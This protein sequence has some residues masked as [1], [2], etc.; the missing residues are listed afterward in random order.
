MTN[1]MFKVLNSTAAAPV[2]LIKAK[3]APPRLPGGLVRRL[4]LHELLDKG[5]EYPLT[6]VKAPAGYGKTTAVLD[7]LRVSGHACCWISL[8]ENDNHPARFFSY[9]ACALEEVLPGLEVRIA[10][11]LQAGPGVGMESALSIIIEELS[12]CSREFILVLDNGHW[13]QDPAI[14]RG[15]SFILEYM[16]LSMHVIIITRQE[17]RLSLSR[18]R[19]KNQVAELGIADL[20]F[21]KT[22]IAAFFRQRDLELPETA[23]VRLEELSEGWAAGLQMAAL[24]MDGPSGAGSHEPDSWLEGF[25]GRNNYVRGYFDEEVFFHWPEEIR[26]F[27]LQTSILKRLN[28]PLCQAVTGTEGSQEILAMLAGANAFILP[29][30]QKQNWYRHHP[31]WAQYLAMRLE[32]SAAGDVRDLHLK[33]GGWCQDKALWEEAIHHFLVAGEHGQALALMEKAA[34]EILENRESGL[35]A[36]WIEQ[37]P[38]EMV[39]GSP[40]LCLASSWNCLLTGD[41]IGGQEWLSRAEASLS[42]ELLAE[43]PRGGGDALMKA[44]IE[45]CKAFQALARGDMAAIEAHSLEARRLIPGKALF[46]KEI[47][48]QH[49]REASLLNTCMGFYGRLDL[50]LQALQSPAYSII[51]DVS[52]NIG[53][54]PAV[55]AEVCYE[56]DQR[57]E[58]LFALGESLPEAER[59]GYMVALIPGIITLARLYRSRG[60]WL[61]ALQMLDDWEERIRPGRYPSWMSLLHACRAALNIEARNEEAAL[62]WIHDQGLSVMDRLDL[63]REYEYITLARLLIGLGKRSDALLLLNGLMRGAEQARR[64]SSVIEIGL[65][66]AIARYQQGENDKSMMSL[67]Q[68]MLLGEKYGYLRRFA[69]EGAA[70]NALIRQYTRWQPPGQLEPA[71]PVSYEYIK[72]IKDLA[73]EMATLAMPAR[74]HGSQA[75][76]PGIFFEE[77]TARE[78]EVLKLLASGSSNAHIA[79]QLGLALAT[80]KFHTKNIFAKLMVSNRVQAVHRA[81]ELF[82]IN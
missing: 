46:Y 18:M 16:P 6:L 25:D 12:S 13:L 44:E 55:K 81:R 30:D 76:N 8:D 78:L 14:E 67:R 37:L 5:R 1:H 26:A 50:C 62:R 28:G 79:S 70:M 20:R 69:D 39:A 58:A 32:N 15:L 49:L 29:L 57:E 64:L 31:L 48:S 65:L 51:R 68:V 61:G 27:L 71:A 74:A 47:S 59:S 38:P 9:V 23:R 66:Q 34:P 10:P 82:L 80:V 35:L 54:L 56:Q 42:G 4:R 3:L 33:A 22:E 41:E 19:V 43:M 11:L 75:V 17:P 73:G 53:M 24:Q 45:L 77:L 40:L 21:Q 7:W 36:A 63:G 60:D 52:T 2:P 72:R